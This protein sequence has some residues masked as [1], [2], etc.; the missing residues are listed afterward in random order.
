M[1]LH[2]TAKQHNRAFPDTRARLY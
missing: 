1:T 2:D